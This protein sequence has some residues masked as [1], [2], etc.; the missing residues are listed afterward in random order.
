MNPFIGPTYYYRV[1]GELEVAVIPLTLG[2][3][4][5]IV[6]RVNAPTYDQGW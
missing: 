5:I 4:R 1:E 6:G 3:A 2:R